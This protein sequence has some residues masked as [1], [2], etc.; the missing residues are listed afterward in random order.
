[1][2]NTLYDEYTNKK[3][4]TAINRQGTV[5]LWPIRLPN[6]NGHIDTWSK[7][8]H[9]AAKLATTHWTRVRANTSSKR[10]ETFVATGKIPEP[11]WPEITMENVLEAA[12]CERYID[13]LDHVVIRRLKGYV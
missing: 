8:A 1:L 10:Y 7:S 13:S 12:F 9:A 4:Y 11:N 3:L 2:R 6:K 5:F